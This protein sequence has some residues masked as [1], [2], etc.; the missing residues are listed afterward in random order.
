M[1]VPLAGIAPNARFVCELSLRH[2]TPDEAQF[3]DHIFAVKDREL[4]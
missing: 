3:E 1:A 4:A 2:S